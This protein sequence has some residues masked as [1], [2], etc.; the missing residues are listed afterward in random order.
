MTMLGQAGRMTL[1]LGCWLLL[2]GSL[3]ARTI[4]LSDEDCPR[5]AAIAA[6]APRLSWAACELG[7]GSFLTN[8]LDMTSSRSFLICYPLDRIPKGQRI[9]NAEWEIPVALTS[10]G[11][12][13]LY[14][15]RIV[16][17][18]G[19]GVCHDYRSVRP[20]KVPWTV[21]GAKGASLD[22][23]LKPSGVMRAAGAGTCK[24]IVTEDVQLWY[25]DAAANQGWILNV[26]D[27][28]SL[29]RL[30]VPL[31]LGRGQWKLRITYEP[32]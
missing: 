2:V 8:Y 22:R 16:G 9:T 30:N 31:Y 27:A 6:E 13:R 21:P 19:V 5:M 15:R 3:P 11:E 32:E 17:D 28:D 26:E 24:L 25:S 12:Q 29:I 14:V 1:A 10:A 7:A 20:K 18:W 23:A 4:I